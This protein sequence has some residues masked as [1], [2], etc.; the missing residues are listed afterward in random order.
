MPNSVEDF[1]ERVKKFYYA[2]AFLVEHLFDRGINA[3]LDLDLPP[4][5]YNPLSNLYVDAYT[6]ACASLEG[7]AY[8]QA[9]LTNIKSTGSREKFVTFL[10]NT[11]VY[12]YLDRVSTPFLLF[13]LRQNSIEKPFCDVVEDKWINNRNERESHRIY[14]DPTIQELEQEYSSCHQSNTIKKQETL[15]NVKIFERFTYASLIYTYYRCSFVHKFKSSKYAVHFN[16]DR[17]ISVR[18]FSVHIYPDGTVEKINKKPQLDVGIKL[19]SAAIR[20]GADLIYDLIIQ[21]GVENIPDL[22]DDLIQIKTK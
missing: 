10:I 5:T 11:S 4:Q 16:Q 17:K 1:S 13:S 21:K 8:I 12:P 3:N 2:R 14:D 15:K 7:L 6:I 22:N 20:K 9:S 19:F 18:E